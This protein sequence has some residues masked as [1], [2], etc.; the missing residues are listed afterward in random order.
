MSDA[1]LYIYNCL[2]NSVWQIDS[3]WNYKAL[4]EMTDF[5]VWL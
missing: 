4:H 2:I 3:N 5:T 1:M